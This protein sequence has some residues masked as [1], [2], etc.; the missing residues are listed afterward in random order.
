MTAI[1]DWNRAPRSIVNR[2]L[3]SA[4]KLAEDFLAGFEDDECQEGMGYKLNHIRTAI[5][6]AEAA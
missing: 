6:K 2:Q 1:N 3:L 4:L 5:E